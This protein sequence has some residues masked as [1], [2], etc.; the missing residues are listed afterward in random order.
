MAFSWTDEIEKYF[1]NKTFTAEA[2]AKKSGKPLLRVRKALWYMVNK[3]GFA[4]R[5][6]D[7]F[8]LTYTVQKEKKPV[9]TKKKPAKKTKSLRQ[10][11]LLHILSKKFGDEEFE[12]DECVGVLSKN[13]LT[14]Y[15]QLQRLFESKMLKRVQ[16]GVYII[17]AK[18]HNKVASCYGAHADPEP[19]PPKPATTVPE[20][21]FEAPLKMAEPKPNGLLASLEGA[22]PHGDLEKWATKVV[23]ESDEWEDMRDR[24]IG[25]AALRDP[26]CRTLLEDKAKETLRAMM[27]GDE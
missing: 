6:G 22:W 15:S 7:T 18:G 26:A 9:A 12:V 1:G 4:S 13:K 11:E 24:L 25:C 17:T 14:V 10:P 19:K 21:T 20:S 8:K 16:K 23:M 27:N 2:L 5:A 3:S